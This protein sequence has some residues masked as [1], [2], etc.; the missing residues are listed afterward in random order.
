MPT[1]LQISDELAA[2]IQLYG[3]WLTDIIELSLLKFRTPT[4]AAAAEIIGFLSRNP[5]PREVLGFHFTDEIQERLSRL[6]ALNSAGLLSA[7]ESC[8]LNDSPYA[9]SCL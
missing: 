2:R 7:D 5:T 9:I 4:A 8:E 1:T 6:L 3:A